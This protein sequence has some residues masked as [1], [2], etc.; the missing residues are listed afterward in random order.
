M[1]FLI[2]NL[3][4]QSYDDF[5]ESF[6][7]IPDYA[8]AL[9]LNDND[10][11]NQPNKTIIAALE[12]LASKKSINSL[13]LTQNN[14]HEKTA[15]ELVEIF[16]AIPANITAL[17]L[18]LNHLGNYSEEELGMILKAIPPHVKKLNLS[19]NGFWQNA[20]ALIEG[21]AALNYVHELN[22][23]FN[24]FDKMTADNLIALMKSLPN[25]ITALKLIGNRFANKTKAEWVNIMAAVKPTVISFHPGVLPADI[26]FAFRAFP[27][28]VREIYLDGSLLYGFPGQLLG[29]AF[30]ALSENVDL[31]S[32]NSAALGRGRDGVLANALKYLNPSVRKLI[33]QNNQLFNKNTRALIELMKSIPLTVSDLNLADNNIGAR[34]ST[35]VAEI[36]EALHERIKTLDLAGNGLF[37]HI[38]TNVL[39]N[40]NNDDLFPEDNEAVCKIFAAIPYNVTS[41]SLART[42][43]IPAK[44]KWIAEALKALHK[45]LD[46]IRLHEV[47]FDKLSIAELEQLKNA[48]PQIKTA[49]L[50][51]HEV[52]QMT[53]EAR[54][55]LWAMLPNA[56][57]ILFVDSDGMELGNTPYEKTNLAREFG[58]KAVPS[59][60][61]CVGFFIKETDIKMNDAPVPEELKTVPQRD[62]GFKF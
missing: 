17:D 15:E 3:D 60:L 11:G 20:S 19:E 44:I 41:L 16:A 53:E 28:G 57:T 50:S 48:L 56:A 40:N 22:L 45:N 46:I 8:T 13:Y 47:E 21:V 58:F 59:L 35:E 23:S 30:M 2:K 26:F 29:Q 12:I 62:E 24:K 5:L 61:S 43:F 38:K 18:S 14:L 36:I 1:H 6:N 55:T 33:L 42:V 7:A 34:P 27:K 25:N 32:L 54:Q 4:Q 10:L 39:S 52:C 9:D 31:L 37:Q 51:Y 49:Y